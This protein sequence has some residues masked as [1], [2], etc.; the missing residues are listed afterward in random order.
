MKK[1]AI[2]LAIFG[3][4]LT[5]TFAQTT[6]SKE[7]PSAV[8]AIQLG[9]FDPNVKQA[10]FEAIRSYAY[11]YKRD[12]LVFV[13]GFASPESAEP[14]LA[15]IKAKGYDDAFVATRSFKKSQTVYVIQL[16][17]RAAG[18]PISWNA[19]AK[20]GDLHTM[21][22]AAQVRIVHGYYT[23][24][25][26]ARVKL[27]EV[28]NMGFPDAFVK[29]VKEV[30]LNPVSDFDTGDKA[31]IVKSDFLK[32]EKGDVV[33]SKG[34]VP[35]AY[36]DMS[37]SKRKSVIKLQEALK[38]V[39]VYGG[40]TDGQFGA[41][42]K[43]SFDKAMKLNR[44][45]KIYDDFSKQYDGFDGW[46]DVRLLMTMARQLSIKETL[47]PMTPDLLGNLPDE[48]LS[49]KATKTALDWHV[50]LWK[51]LEKWSATSQYNDQVYTAMKIAY[52][53]SLVHLEDYYSSKGIKGENGTAL[54]ASVLRTLIA[55]DL[56]G[57]N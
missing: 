11:V 39:G 49:A 9:A 6:Q 27:K 20:V 54:A 14:T 38:E 36:S 19:Y 2:S 7:E 13:G 48:V 23:D 50:N 55:E 17:S 12:G 47:S 32:S 26:D 10:D 43:T 28:A 51:G 21:P 24:V 3:S 45:L 22:N 56:D 35:K 53:R 44:R 40:A 16:A 46:E 33:T 37:S 5:A 29:A 57:F 41:G 25:N 8:Y 15:K 18:E 42:T 1:I 34:I 52:Y 30:Q 31:L 4:F